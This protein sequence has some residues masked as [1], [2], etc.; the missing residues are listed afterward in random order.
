MGPL[1]RETIPRFLNRPVRWVAAGRLQLLRQPTEEHPRRGPLLAA[2]CNFPNLV[3]LAGVLPLCLL[4]TPGGYA[5]LPPLIVYNNLM[6]DLDGMLARAMRLTTHFG[7][8][9]DNVCDAA[10]HTMITMAVGA[11]FGGWALLAAMAPSAAI[12]VR[13][14]GRLQPEGPDGLGST[15][16]ELMRHLL[17]LILLERAFDVAI[18]G[19]VIGVFLIHAVTLVAPIPMPHL[20][21]SRARRVWA[22]GAINASLVVALLAPMWSAL[23][24][25]PFGV[26]F[27]SSLWAGLAGRR[28]RPQP[29]EAED[30]D[31]VRQGCQR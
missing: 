27:V 24:A 14:T 10:G 13:M 21:R 31:P 22:V 2:Y 26:T 18:R 4:L 9:L 8:R 11:H 12:L 15:T 1:T 20:L 30:L 16:N 5:F 6:D 7:F 19:W 3:S 23:I 17:F 25:L 28:S 29:A